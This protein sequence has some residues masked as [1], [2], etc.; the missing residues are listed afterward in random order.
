MRDVGD[1]A[2]VVTGRCLHYGE[3]IT[4]W[5][6]V[7]VLP[8]ARRRRGGVLGMATPAE[9]AVATRHVLESEA[10]ER[11]LVV[12]FDDIQWAEPT[13]L[14]LVEH[15]VDWSRGAAIFLLCIARPELLELQPSWG[16][17]KPNATS[18]LLEP[19]GEARPR[20]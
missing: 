12:I 9:A 7:E 14:E 17:G 1:S 6:L 19:L 4:Y 18:L 15:I 5:P 10:L 11:P 20:R 13:F 3:G 16:G 8:P 2:N